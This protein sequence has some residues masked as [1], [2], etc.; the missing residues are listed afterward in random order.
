MRISLI[1]F[2]LLASL[3]I[4]A[5]SLDDYVQ[6]ALENN[7]ALQQQELSVQQAMARLDQ[8]KALFWPRISIE[9]RY[10][11]ARGGRAFTFPSGDLVNPAYQNLN[12]LNQAASGVDPDYPAFPVYGEIDN[13][14]INFLRETEQETSIRLEMPVFNNT[15]RHNQRLRENQLAAAQAGW[16]VYRQALAKDVR[17]AYYTYAQ[18]FYGHSIYQDALA[19]VEENLRTT[20]S[21]Q[22]NHKVTAAAVYAAQAEVAKVEQEL[23]TAR[24]QEQSALAYF[25]FLLNRD[26]NAAVGLP[27]EPTIGDVN[28]IGLEAARQQGMQQ[29]REL[30]QFNHYLAATRDGIN[31]ARGN[32]LPTVNLRADYGIQGTNYTFSR[33]ADF[34]MGSVVF[35]IPLFDRSTSSKVEEAKVAYLELSKQREEVQQQIGLQIVN[36]H[37]A[38]TAAQDRIESAQAQRHAAAEAFRLTN[39][40]YE[41]GQANQI[42]FTEARTQLTNAQENLLIA[43]F[44]YQIKLAELEWAMANN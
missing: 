37:Y 21:L 2:F 3:S 19:L 12:V 33:D 6:I 18:A 4:Q 39:R 31:I 16:D 7:L 43:Q 11:V 38:L 32:R 20:E 40:M 15:I 10:S 41:Q 1:S 8:A 28:V 42:A 30:E 35:S 25:N 13:Q 44:D 24:Q 9:G 27:A 22:R 34:F 29:R 23:A 14:E 36:Q 5:Q 26:Y 17:V